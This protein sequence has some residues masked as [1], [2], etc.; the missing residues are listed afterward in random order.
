MLNT[1]QAVSLIN[2]QVICEVVLAMAIIV[3]FFY[4]GI[5]YLIFLHK[6]NKH[7]RHECKCVRCGSIFYDKDIKVVCDKCLNQSKESNNAN[8]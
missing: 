3:L 7:Q 8:N 6:I 1:E 4:N 2:F 5:K